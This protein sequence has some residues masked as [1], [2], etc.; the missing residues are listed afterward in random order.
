MAVEY[1]KKSHPSL[2]FKC[3]HKF[4][5]MRMDIRKR[6]SIRRAFFGIKA[7]RDA[8]YC[9]DIVYSASLL[10]ICYDFAGFPA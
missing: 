3:L 10:E 2:L 9:P 1:K 4:H 6:K 5:L 7:D 8:L